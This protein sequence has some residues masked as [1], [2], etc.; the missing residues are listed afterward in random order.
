[1]LES[2]ATV[3]GYLALFLA[4]IIAIYTLAVALVVYWPVRFEC[5]RDT[6]INLDMPGRS[7]PVNFLLA[8]TSRGKD[9]WVFG[10][11]LIDKVAQEPRRSRIISRKSGPKPE[12][13]G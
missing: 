13:E 2:F 3:I 7:K 4:A 12:G 11:M 5:R 10:F 8:L 1:M 6:Q 9:R